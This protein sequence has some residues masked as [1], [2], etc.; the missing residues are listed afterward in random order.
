[1]AI[2]EWAHRS[3]YNIFTIESLAEFCAVVIELLGIFIITGLA[4]YTL[5]LAVYRLFGGVGLQ[6]AFLQVRQRF[7]RGILL[8]LEFFIAADII[9]TVAIDLVVRN[10]LTLA[11]VILMRTFLSFTLEMELTGHWPWHDE[12]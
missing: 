3:G 8:G 2:V 6:A 10:L 4:L 1:M 11:I 5:I 7:G 12:R 9:R